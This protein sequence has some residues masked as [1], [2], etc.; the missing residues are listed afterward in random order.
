VVFIQKGMGLRI[1]PR[2]LTFRVDESGKLVLD[3]LVFEIRLDIWPWWLDIG[4]DHAAQA[5]ASRGRLLTVVGG[6]EGEKA[7]ALESECK[8]GMVA[9]SAAAFAL[10]AFSETTRNFV[11]GMDEL[12]VAWNKAGTPR[13]ARVTETLR[14]AF[15]FDN[16]QAKKLRRMAGT[17][18]RF[19]GWAVHPPADYRTPFLHDLLSVGVEWRFVAFSAPNAREAV[20]GVTNA[21]AQCLQVPRSHGAALAEWCEGV[22]PEADARKAR[23]A[24][25][26]GPSFPDPPP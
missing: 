16:Q 22:R 2:G 15:R 14:R 25:Q 9:I 12:I 1:P 17:Y 21:I 13:H 6:P 20:L 10:D 8:A 23:C 11:P 5:L 7:D 24:E 19:R 3:D 4:I 26:L 18:F